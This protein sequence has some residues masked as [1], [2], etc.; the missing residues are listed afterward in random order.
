MRNDPARAG[1]PS[2]ASSPDRAAAG[3]PPAAGGSSRATLAYDPACLACELLGHRWA[4]QIVAVLL[5]GPHRFSAIHAAIPALSEKVLSCR[6]AEFEAAGI[7]TRTQY[8]EIPPRVEYA[9]TEAGLALEPVIAEMARW[10]REA[11][12]ATAPAEGR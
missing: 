1:H 11:G 7:A 3:A 5:S 10:S 4:F 9:L 6:L 12:A 8:P 2:G